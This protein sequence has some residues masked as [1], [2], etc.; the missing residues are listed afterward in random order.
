MEER[1]RQLL[2]D[3]LQLQA[4]CAQQQEQLLAIYS[5][6]KQWLDEHDK[7]RESSEGPAASVGAATGGPQDGAH[8]PSASSIVS[9]RGRGP[10]AAEQRVEPAPSCSG[11][12][13][14]RL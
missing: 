8:A 2:G 5:E 14:L 10:R 1:V 7:E 13:P 9:A 4:P 11:S 6:A 3:G 12:G